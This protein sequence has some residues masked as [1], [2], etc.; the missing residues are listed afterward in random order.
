M[1]SGFENG[2]HPVQQLFF[3]GTK[4]NSLMRVCPIR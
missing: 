2:H 4:G 3:L 1:K